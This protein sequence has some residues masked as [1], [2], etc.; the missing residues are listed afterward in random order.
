L[1]YFTK[2]YGLV[3]EGIQGRAST[4]PG[5]A[6][7]QSYEQNLADLDPVVK[8]LTDGSVR[9]SSLLHSDETAWIIRTLWRDWRR[10]ELRY[11]RACQR[12]A[13]SETDQALNILIDHMLRGTQTLIAYCNSSPSSWDPSSSISAAAKIGGN[14]FQNVFMSVGVALA[15]GLLAPRVVVIVGSLAL[16]TGRTGFGVR[17]GRWSGWGTMMWCASPSTPSNR[18]VQ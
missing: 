15:S 18:I 3:G 13:I 4:S 5:S 14:K 9:L 16:M 10:V 6:W 17:P 8:D 1:P 11:F 7:C 12:D 2:I